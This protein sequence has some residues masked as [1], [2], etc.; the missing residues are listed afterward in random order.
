M[1]SIFLNYEI[2]NNYFEMTRSLILSL[3]KTIFGLKAATADLVPKN[4][5]WGFQ[6]WLDHSKVKAY[7]KDMSADFS[8]GEQ[9]SLFF[10]YIRII[11][12]KE[13]SEILFTVLSSVFAQEP[14]PKAIF[15]I[16][17]NMKVS[18]ERRKEGRKKGRKKSRK[19]ERQK[20]K[21]SK[22]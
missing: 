1:I 21:E 18:V 5:L 14:A 20:E 13:S 15:F 9:T 11:F 2:Q 19:R 16:F 22:R 8:Y 12:L 3:F 7:S 10:Q 6:I 17:Y 4:E